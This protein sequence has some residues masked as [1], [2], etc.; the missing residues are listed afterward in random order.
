MIHKN[1]GRI[2]Y[3]QNHTNH[4]KTKNSERIRQ[5]NGR[6]FAE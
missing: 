3:P 2:N 6:Y 4:L 1:R 5:W